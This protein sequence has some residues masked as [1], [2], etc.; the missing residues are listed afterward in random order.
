MTER[1]PAN[2]SFESWID[3]QIRA[4]HDRGEFTDLPGAGKPLRHH[5]DDMWWLKEF[6][7]R[8]ELETGALLP[9]GLRLR[10][11]V[12][13]LPAAA[14]A[15]PTEERV[16]AL[17]G[18]LNERIDTSLRSHTGPTVLIRFVDPDE[19]VAGWRTDRAALLRRLAEAEAEAE[20]EPG[21]APA[22]RR[23]WRRG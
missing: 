17:V 12:E 8:E 4:A 23:W 2:V 9:E 16:R 14:A 19:I 22:R 13:L 3:A 11:E 5:D 15:L 10:K 18:E 7:K 20:V 6:I 1:K 21:P